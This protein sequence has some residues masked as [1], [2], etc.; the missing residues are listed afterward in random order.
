MHTLVTLGSQHQGVMEVPGCGLEAAAAVA[1]VASK[2]AVV[3]EQGGAAAAMAAAAKGL[4]VEKADSSI[5][6]GCVA[7]A[8]AAAAVAN[9]VLSISFSL[10]LAERG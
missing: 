6:E 10:F 4:R 8:A 7:A 3:V 5:G 1:A 2:K 9:G